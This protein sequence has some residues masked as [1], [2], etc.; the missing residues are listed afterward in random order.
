MKIESPDTL[1]IKC[2]FCLVVYD[3]TQ[4]RCGVSGLNGF[5][6]LP[7]IKLAKKILDDHR[8]NDDLNPK[9]GA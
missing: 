7:C 4:G 8:N 2:G 9:Q 5:I 1:L 6:C 3:K